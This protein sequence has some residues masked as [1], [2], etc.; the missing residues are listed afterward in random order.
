MN[1][2]STDLAPGAG[3][4]E[5]AQLAALIGS[6]LCHDIVSPLGAIGNGLELLQISDQFPGLA[7]SPELLLIAE[8]V[9][10]ARVR[11]KWFRMAFGHAAADQRLAC[12]EM[13]ALFREIEQGGRLRVTLDSGG[14]LP[15]TEA[16]MILLGLMCV[17]TAMPWGGQVQILRTDTGWR[18]AAEASRTR[19]TPELWAWLEGRQGTALAEPPAA[20][21]HFPL[22]AAFAREQGRMISWSVGDNRAEM[23]F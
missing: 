16:R 7:K 15:R 2:Y 23:A 14:D 10:A 5:A 20:E 13:A 1:A 6:R 19:R 22:L 8:S 17:E 4:L 9:Q 3:Q 18:L 21:V 12:N 11:I